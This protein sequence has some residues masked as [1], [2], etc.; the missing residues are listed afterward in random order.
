MSK[1]E[2]RQKMTLLRA[3]IKRYDVHRWLKTFVSALN[4]G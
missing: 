3:Q 1:E 4:G 2:Q